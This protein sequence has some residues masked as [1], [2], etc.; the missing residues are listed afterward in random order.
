MHVVET[1]VII[2]DQEI[3]TC[4]F[5]QQSDVDNVLGLSSSTTRNMDKQ[6]IVHSI[7]LYLEEELKPTIHSK[8]RG[9]LTNG[10]FLHHNIAQPHMVAAAIEIVLKLVFEVF[11]HTAY[12]ANLT[13]SEYHFFRHQICLTWML[14]FKW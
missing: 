10:V 5:C 8:C 4:F 7:V 11:S 12:S 2:Q 13:S 9:M 1:R 3:K 14:I 6:S